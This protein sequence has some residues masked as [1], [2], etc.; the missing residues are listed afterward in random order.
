[1]IDA[2]SSQ[3]QLHPHRPFYLLSASLPL[4]L[5]TYQPLGIGAAGNAVNLHDARYT[6]ATWMLEQGISPKTVQTM[7]EHSSISVTLDVYSHVS[8]TLEKQAAATLNAALTGGQ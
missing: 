7:L 3:V 5:P 1:M 4:K 8:L 2:T 6:Y